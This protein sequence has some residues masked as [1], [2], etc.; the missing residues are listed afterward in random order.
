MFHRNIYNTNLV[1]IYFLPRCPKQRVRGNFFNVKPV[2]LLFP[3]H[4]LNEVN[5]AHRLFLRQAS[6]LTQITKSDANLVKLNYGK[7][8]ERTA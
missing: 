3:D 1:K 2:L 7:T 8:V 6:C 5:C 4:S